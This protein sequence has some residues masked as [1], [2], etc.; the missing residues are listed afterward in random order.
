LFFFFSEVT[1]EKCLSLTSSVF[2]FL[3]DYFFIGKVGT[4][5]T[6]P[7]FRFTEE[8][9]V[10]NP[11][12]FFSSRKNKIRKRILFFL[13]KQSYL[14]MGSPCGVSLIF[15]FTPNFLWALRPQK[16]LYFTQ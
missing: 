2:V 9:W 14:K 7:F 15:N 1:S 16:K 5:L 6:Q 8:G 10:K 13:V 12:L 3:R 11:Y 4:L